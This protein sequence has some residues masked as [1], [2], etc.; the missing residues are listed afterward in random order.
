MPDELMIDWGK[1]RSDAVAQINLPAINAADVLGVAARMYTPNR[2]TLV[3]EHT[4]GC[5]V[6]GVS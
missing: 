4:V 1:T 3:D 5:P 2:L 6:G